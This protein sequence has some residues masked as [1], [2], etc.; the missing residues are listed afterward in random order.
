MA[1]K[2]VQEYVILNGKPGGFFTAELWQKP[3]VG[4]MLAETN[5]YGT[6]RAA[7]DAAKRI[8]R[9]KLDRNGKVIS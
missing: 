5:W 4:T 2:K 6:R 1:G 7:R 3:F 8:F 9:R